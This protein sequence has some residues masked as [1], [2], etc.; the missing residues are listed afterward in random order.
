MEIRLT[1]D[2]RIEE[3]TATEFNVQQINSI[4]HVKGGVYRQKSKTPTFCV[5]LSRHLSHSH[6]E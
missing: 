1:P 6:G 2:T 3:I 4:K 5:D